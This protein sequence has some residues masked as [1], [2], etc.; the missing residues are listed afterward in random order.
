M[1][2]NLQLNTILTCERIVQGGS[3]DCLWAL[4]KWWI[5]LENKSLDERWSIWNVGTVRN[6]MSASKTHFLRYDIKHYTVVNR[7]YREHNSWCYLKVHLSVAYYLIVLLHLYF[8]V[9]TSCVE[10]RSKRNG[11]MKDGEHYLTNNNQFFKVIQI[12][13]NRLLLSTFSHLSKLK[14]TR[15]YFVVINIPLWEA[16]L[17]HG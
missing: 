6:R 5:N 17:P 13:G 1:S 15:G 4:H 14:P 9:G 11:I 3:E 8:L 10:A 12:C 2:F 7:C 16:R